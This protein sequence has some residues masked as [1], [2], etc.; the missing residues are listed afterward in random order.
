MADDIL[1]TSKLQISIVSSILIDKNNPTW[2]KTRK[3]FSNIEE[4]QVCNVKKKG[5]QNV[6]F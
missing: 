6:T 5:K 1:N 4:W 2:V 3:S